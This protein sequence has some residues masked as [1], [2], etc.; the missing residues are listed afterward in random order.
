MLLVARD[1][2]CEL[3]SWVVVAPLTT[4]V[5]DVP[6]VVLLDPESD[7]V[8]RSSMVTLDNLMAVPI[9]WLC[10]RMTTLSAGVTREVDQAIHFALGLEE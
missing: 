2:A 6:T 3:L 4:T 7:G 8:D 1:E 5:R 10:E 9:A